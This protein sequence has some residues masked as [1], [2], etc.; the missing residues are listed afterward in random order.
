MI[1]EKLYVGSGLARSAQVKQSVMEYDYSQGEWTTLPLYLCAHF[2]MAALND[3]LVLFG[4]IL[5]STGKKTSIVGV[6]NEKS[7]SWTHPLPPMPTARRSPSVV[8]H[9]DRWLVVI[10]GRCED[11][12]TQLSVV[13]ILD[14]KLG[15]WYTGE[16]SPHPLSH[17]SVAMVGGSTCYLIGGFV[18]KGT[19]SKKTFRVDLEDLV[20]QATATTT[21]QTPST[22]STSRAVLRSPWLV[23][24]NTPH[25]HSSALALHGT[26]LAVGG[27]D[28][29]ASKSIFRYEPDAAKWIKA[30]E[31]A[32]SRMMCACLAHSNRIFVAG[33]MSAIIARVVSTNLM[34]IAEYHD[35]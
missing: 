20:C 26:L 15:Q 18:M 22:T 12:H 6:W 16:S 1:K 9:K 27:E 11:R 4:G 2:G 28:I 14:T 17:G 31:L 34:E 33:G 29:F 13:E 24:P 7:Q 30:G 25:I 32:S 8:T 35:C 21:S 10:G 5:T 23:L 3:D 19:P